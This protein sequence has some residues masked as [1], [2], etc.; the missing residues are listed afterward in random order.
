MNVYDTANKLAQEIKQSE[1]YVTYKMAKEA[2]NLNPELKN[3]ID[4]FEKSRYEAQIIALQTGKQDDEKEIS[5]QALKI[6]EVLI[7]DDPETELEKYY[8]VAPNSY[9]K[10]FAGVSYLTKEFGDRT[11]DGTSLYLR[12]LNNITEEMQIE[13]LK[14]DELNYVFQSISIIAILPVLFIDMVKNWAI[15][16]FSFTSSFYL[17]SVGFIVQTLLLIIS[18]ICF[19]LVRKVKDTGSVQTITNENPWQRKLYAKPY[20]KKIVDKF[21]PKKGTKEYRKLI[22][23]LK[24]AASKQKTEWLYLNRIA[25]CIIAFICSIVFFELLHNVVVKFTYTDISASSSIVGM[26][27]AEAE[28]A[29]AQLEIDNQFLD[30]YKRKEDYKRAA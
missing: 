13:I 21:I 14:R 24:D 27:D 22:Q 11:I 28:K 8:D 16:Q 26:T 4:E 18:A 10:E 30:K 1:E 20:V 23:L 3:K 25:M 7:S 2:I 6:Y 19:I 5:Q 9:L 29:K 12:N 17:G 15:S